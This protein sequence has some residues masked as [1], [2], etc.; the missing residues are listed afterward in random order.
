MTSLQVGEHF[1]EHYENKIKSVFF[2]HPF[3]A[4][5]TLLNRRALGGKALNPFT[6]MLTIKLDCAQLNHQDGPKTARPHAA[7]VTQTGSQSR[8]QLGMFSVEH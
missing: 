1:E 8:E 6:P 2:S 5:V 7:R 3:L 4:L